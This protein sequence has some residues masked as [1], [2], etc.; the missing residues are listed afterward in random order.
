MDT[1][2]YHVLL[3]DCLLAL[4]LFGLFWY[5]ARLARSVRG[6]KAWGGAHLVYTLGATLLDAFAPALMQAGDPAAAKLAVNTGSLLA[7]IGM[8]GLAWS[9]ILFTTQRRLSRIEIALMPAA[10]VMALAAWALDGTTEGQGI[11]LSAVEIVAL[12]I[13]AWRL[14]RM[15]DRPGRLPARLM[16]GGCVALM[17]LYGS[18]VPGWL[19]GLFGIDPIWVSVDLSIWFMLNF[20]MLMLTSF[21]A[22]ESWR[23][24][25]MHDLLTGLLNR[26][27]LELEWQSRIARLPADTE[28][29]AVAL[30]LD[31]FKS[32]NDHHG[33]EAGDGVLQRFATIVRTCLPEHALFARLGGEE[34][35]VVL[36]GANAASAQTAAERIRMEVAAAEFATNGTPIRVSCSLGVCVGGALRD[37]FA[38]L[39]RTAD[40][41]LYDAK[42]GGRDRVA[43]RAY[44]G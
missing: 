18:V 38:D 22:A 20:C 35:V 19:D 12:A 2:I 7:C 32:V 10:I 1:D 30:D 36:T 27:G 13:M 42:R 40:Q 24:G 5:V 21:R 34:F 3:S 37:A 33:H 14:Y 26:R 28:I 6:I 44:A 43:L 39:L 31:R 16:A 25:A 17:L 11:A 4:V 15:R 9:I 23:H 41:A 29:A 8:V